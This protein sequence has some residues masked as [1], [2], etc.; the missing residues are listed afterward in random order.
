M[1]RPPAAAIRDL[2]VFGCLGDLEKFR[3]P[4]RGPKQAE[5]AQKW[6]FTA[7]GAVLDE[8]PAEPNLIAY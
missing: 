3:S 1:I 4:I 2:L 8:T 6:I 5:N 7:L